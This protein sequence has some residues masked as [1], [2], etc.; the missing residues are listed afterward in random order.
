MNKTNIEQ[1]P[2]LGTLLDVIGLAKDGGTSILL[3]TTTSDIV[4]D[5]GLSQA[6]LDTSPLRPAVRKWLFL[7]HAHGDHTGGFD[8]FLRDRNFVIATGALTLELLLAS[9]GRRSDLDRSLPRDFF[10]RVAPM[11]YGSSYHFTDG[12]S[13]KPVP[14]YHFPGSMGF[15][16]RFSGGKT[17]FYSGDL[18]VRGA[19]L[20]HRLGTAPDSPLQFDAG[21]QRV[22]I[23]IIEAAFVGRPIGVE[24]DRA[25]SIVSTVQRL[26]DAGRHVVLL[27]PPADYGLYLFL[28]L[29]S[30]V[31]AKATRT[32][33]AKLFLDPLILEQ[34][35]L[36]EW[37]MKRK[38]V[39][40]LDSACLTWLASRSTLGESV[41]VFDSSRDLVTNV[42]ELVRRRM[43]GVFLLSDRLASNSTY[44]PSAAR[45]ALEAD[46]VDTV[47]VGKAATVPS[48]GNDGECDTAFGGAPWLLH[49]SEADLASY[50]LSGPQRFGRVY[51]FHNFKR[52]LQKFAKALIDR[53]FQGTIEA[54]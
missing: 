14:T 44:F 6:E 37:R 41:R 30:S 52:R 29:Y 48:N 11:W 1:Q 47:L 43:K 32:V 8:L 36:L 24:A 9:I 49:S 45:E 4:L 25:D 54:L 13:V 31:I 3:R 12:S 18:N 38:Q 16:F 46:G 33:D 26:I 17:L 51:L 7:S 2:G 42:R 27:A 5:A 20:A 23:G 19:Y 34:L 21:P 39:G 15:L 53:G 50:L 40:S 28:H 10:Y 22:D 35:A